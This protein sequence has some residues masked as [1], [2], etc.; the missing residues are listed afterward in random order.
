MSEVTGVNA[1]QNIIYHRKTE[2]NKVV[3]GSISKQLRPLI[4]D[5]IDLSPWD[6]LGTVCAATAEELLTM[7]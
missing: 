6:S 7:N 4:N 1:L 5:V 3:F 2:D